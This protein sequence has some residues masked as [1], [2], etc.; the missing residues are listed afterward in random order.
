VS[1][2]GSVD[3]KK[4]DSVTWVSASLDMLLDKGD[5]IQTGEN[6]FARVLFEDGTEYSIKA[7]TLLTVEVNDVSSTMTN[8]AVRIVVGNVDL[9]T[10]GGGQ[11][12]SIVA[13]SV[14]DSVALIRQNTKATVDNDPKHNKRQITVRAG[15]ALVRRRNEEQQLNS[16]ERIDLPP[17]SSQAKMVKSALL[18]PPDLVAPLN[19]EP[20]IADQSRDSVIH[21]RWL[22]VSGAASYKLRISRDIGFKLL[23]NPEMQV[24]GTSADIKGL[25]EGTYF[26]CLSATNAKKEPSGDSDVFQFTV[27][28]KKK[29]QNLLLEIQSAVVHGRFAEI[30]GKTEPGAALIINGMPVAN[31]SQDGTFRHFTD[32]L[33]PGEHRIIVLGSNRRGCAASK[34]L[35]L[36]ITN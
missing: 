13:I 8:T 26:W 27:M 24:S 32:K 10:P 2:N 17:P 9:A 35:M 21:F 3:V 22:P 1:L 28:S 14:D 6:G 34:E 5:R 4:R 15:G 33:E 30:I 18:S 29:S 25:A 16:W 19:F 7:E 31:I 11:P 36:T 20:I 23:A 12:E